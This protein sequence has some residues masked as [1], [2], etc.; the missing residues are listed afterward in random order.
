MVGKFDINA[1][2]VDYSSLQ[3]C[4][5]LDPSSS[6]IRL[7]IEMQRRQL[8]ES[9]PAHLHTCTPLM[10]Q[11]H[12]LHDTKP[13]HQVITQ[14]R[15]VGHLGLANDEL[16][17]RL[18]QEEVVNDTRPPGRDS[19]LAAETCVAYEGMSP[20]VKVTCIGVDTEVVLLRIIS[21]NIH[22]TSEL[23][24]SAHLSPVY[25]IVCKESVVKLGQNSHDMCIFMQ[26]PQIF[27][28][29]L[30]CARLIPSGSDKRIVLPLIEQTQVLIVVVV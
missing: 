27:P 30:Q 21:A 11:V 28:V 5:Q 17:S 9:L 10:R 16:C 29:L 23:Q 6:D 3:L 20:T 18:I 13:T 7:T 8:K 12:I 14:Y 22:Q 24:I 19:V 2:F 1:N 4:E 15:A 25:L 26:L